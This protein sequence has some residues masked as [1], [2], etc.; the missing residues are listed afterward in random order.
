[1]LRIEKLLGKTPTVLKLSG[2]IQEE[3]LSVLQAEI[4]NCTDSPKLDLK[5]LNL[6]DRSTVRFLIQCESQGIQLVN[7]PLF[8]QEWITRERRRTAPPPNSE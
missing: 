2:R 3:T 7:C 8:I 5:D 1:M 6:L 4:E